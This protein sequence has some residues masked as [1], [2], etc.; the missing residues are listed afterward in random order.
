[1]KPVDNSIAAMAGDL[2]EWRRHLHRNPELLYDLPRTAAFVADKLRAF[3]F[4]EVVE[5]VGRSGVVG[6]LRGDGPM[7]E[8]TTILLRADM[9]ALPMTE[10]TG[11]PH[12]SGTPGLM[13]ACGH[14]GHTVMLLGAARRLAE[15]RGFA[16]TVVFCFQPAEEGGA[17][18]KAMLD[19]GL[20]ERW[21]ARACFGVHNWPGV[22]LG[23]ACIRPG[24][25]TA[26]A[27]EFDILI[28]GRGSHAAE[29][30]RAAD[31]VAAGCALHAALQTIVSRRVDPL[32]PAVVS[33]TLFQAGSARNVIPGTAR[34]AGT[35]R[36]YDDATHALMRDEVRLKCDRIGA[37]HGVTITPEFMGTPY[38]ATINAAAAAAEAERAA[39][40]AMGEES[41]IR[42]FPPSMAG[43]DFS[44]LARERPSAFI[45]LGSG[46]ISPLHSTDYDFDDAL[47]PIGANFWTRLVETALPK[48]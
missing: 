48:G 31:P 25:I 34:L 18:A 41:V 26:M 10:K 43:E 27:D 47:S 24:P 28:E 16:G 20:L 40:E 46:D 17:G 36:S 5:G 44:F 7:R 2:T 1:M 23:S 33:V 21:P 29:P 3:G 22:P 45:L 38:P 15:T 4:D 39:I 32:Q 19:D 42:E 37:A 14:D 35:L 30:H 12:A 11:A 8:E 9:D 13:H 6:V